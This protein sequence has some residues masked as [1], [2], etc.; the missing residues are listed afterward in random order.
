MQQSASEMV[1]KLNDIVWLL[2]PAQE[3]LEKAGSRSWKIMQMTCAILK[4]F[5]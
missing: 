5:I 2:N 1:A 3:S 4:T